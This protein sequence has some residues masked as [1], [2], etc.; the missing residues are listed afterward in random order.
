[1][2][3]LKGE[4]K[5]P[6]PLSRFSAG[7]FAYVGN[8]SDLPIW[9][10]A[11]SAVIADAPRAVQ[12]EVRGSTTVQAE[13]ANRAS[14]LHSMLRA[15]RPWSKKHAGVFAS[16]HGARHTDIATWGHAVCMFLSFSRP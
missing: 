7:G 13:F 4:A 14:P 3:N 1:M 12:A 10:A 5:A 16:M 2:R 9:P 6:A 8:R 11:G 15:M